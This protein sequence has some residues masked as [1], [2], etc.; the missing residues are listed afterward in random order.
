MNRQDLRVKNLFLH[1]VYNIKYL[2]ENR[3]MKRNGVFP[4]KENA[5][6]SKKGYNVRLFA[7]V[8]KILK[9]MVPE[10]QARWE[11]LRNQPMYEFKISSDLDLTED[12]AHPIVKAARLQQMLTHAE[13][14]SNLSTLINE[15]D[16]SGCDFNFRNI[17]FRRS[18]AWAGAKDPT[19]GILDFSKAFSSGVPIPKVISDVERICQDWYS[20]NLTP[21]IK[22]RILKNH[23]CKLL[24]DKM[25]R[26]PYDRLSR[27]AARG[28]GELTSAQRTKLEEFHRE[29][30][31]TRRRCRGVS[32]NQLFNLV[33]ATLSMN[34]SNEYNFVTETMYNGYVDDLKI[35]RG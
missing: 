1:L 3:L 15:R 28:R 23:L 8:V 11:K 32:D 20:V 16:N 9:H 7:S 29:Y 33:K 35:E 26:V 22:Q 19:C 6:C 34:G 10:T 13:L 14:P 24:K 4:L 21:E 2:R 31:S 12:G 5:N 17:S 30:L 27:S 18:G 25:S